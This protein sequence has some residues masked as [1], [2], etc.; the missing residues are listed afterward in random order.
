MIGSLKL[1]KVFEY[2]IVFSL[3]TSKIFSESIKEK[4]MILY[5]PEVHK[6]IYYGF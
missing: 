5:V 4:E 2:L 6:D 1:F 3:R